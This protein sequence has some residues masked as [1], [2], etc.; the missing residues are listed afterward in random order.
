MDSL[1]LDT[2]YRPVYEY[3]YNRNTYH[4]SNKKPHI[5]YPFLKSVQEKDIRG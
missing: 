1:L 5:L 4:S 3:K 2:F